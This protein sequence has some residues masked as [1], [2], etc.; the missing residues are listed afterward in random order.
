MATR[1]RIHRDDGQHDEELYAEFEAKHPDKVAGVAIRQLSTSEAVLAGGRK[2]GLA[3][4]LHGGAPWVYGGDGASL[5][6]Q[7]ISLG[8]IEYQ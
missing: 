7:L 3:K 5:F 8:V 2:K 4:S 6:D 1:Y